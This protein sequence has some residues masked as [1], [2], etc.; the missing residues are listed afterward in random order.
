MRG[1]KEVI[2]TFMF[3]S[4]ALGMHEAAWADTVPPS[5]RATGEAMLQGATTDYLRISQ[6]GDCE[7]AL[8]KRGQEKGTA[9][10]RILTTR[11]GSVV[12][13]VVRSDRTG[14]Y[15]VWT[16]FRNN[17]G[18]LLADYPTDGFSGGVGPTFAVSAPVYNGM[19]M[20]ENGFIVSRGAGFVRIFLDYPIL[21]STGKA[22]LVPVV[23][24][25]LS[26]HGLNRVGGFWLRSYSL[27][28]ALEASTQKLMMIPLIDPLTGQPRVDPKTGEPVLIKKRD[29]TGLP[30]P[31]VKRATATGLIVVFHPNETTHG[32]T[33]GVRDVDFVP[34]FF[35]LF[36]K[37]CVP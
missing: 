11:S 22:G 27:D 13:V 3:C 15:T 12:E 9:T 6:P 19:R 2:R 17:L 7:F 26:M 23:G 18:E 16:N 14:V 34:G 25:K 36:P 1:T 35:G 37:T 20:D 30:I 21:T 33:P 8:E 10:A 24:E 4:I 29:R 5:Q 28:H 31:V 32:H